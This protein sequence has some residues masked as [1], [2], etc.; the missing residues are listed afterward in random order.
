[1]S[2]S[3]FEILVCKGPECAGKG[4]ADAI[5]ERLCRAV[6]EQRVSDQVTLGR[7]NCF[8]RCSRG[9]NVYVRSHRAHM[10]LA[11]RPK[12]SVLYSRVAVHD[13]DAIVTQHLIGGRV[14]EHLIDDFPAP[15]DLGPDSSENA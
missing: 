6:A 13:V 3:T 8:G 2:H 4:D 14:L 9:P 15:D 11:G 12:I 5:H 7:K 1:V 10:H